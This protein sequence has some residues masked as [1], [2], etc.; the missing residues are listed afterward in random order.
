MIVDENNPKAQNPSLER[1]TVLNF[2]KQNINSDISN[3]DIQFLN[4]AGT[5]WVEV[6][7]L[8]SLIQPSIKTVSYTHLTLPT[9]LLV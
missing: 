1:I 8:C 7:Q 9:I 4:A 2:D 3:K 5:M 6:E